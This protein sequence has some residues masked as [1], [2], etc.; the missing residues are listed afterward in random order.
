MEIS[1]SRIIIIGRGASLKHFPLANELANCLTIGLNIS[2]FNNHKFDYSFTSESFE[3]NLLFKDVQPIFVGSIKFKLGVLLSY[4]DKRSL[5]DVEVGL[6]GFDFDGYSRDDDILK[7]N[8]TSSIQRRVDIFSQLEALNRLKKSFSRVKIV[9]FGFDINSD[10]DPRLGWYGVR[11]NI[12]K[13]NVEV[14]AEI[15][16]NHHGDTKKLLSLIEGAKTA[17]AN[18][19]KL[20]KRDVNTF[21]S[22][23]KL[24]EVYHSPFGKTF[25]D[26]RMALE[27]TTEQ[28]YLAHELAKE[29]N[30]NIFYSTLDLPSYQWAIKSGFDRVKLPSTISNKKRFLNEVAKMPTKELV[31]STGMTDNAYEEWILNTFKKVEKIFLLQCTS[32]Y[33]TFYKDVNLGVVSH[34]KELSKIHPSVL[35]GLSSH[36]SGSIASMMAVAAGAKM[37][38]KH[39][40]IGVNDWS[41][42]D[43]TAL[44]VGTAFNDFVSEIRLAEEIMGDSKKKVLESEHH[45]Y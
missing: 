44:D 13:Y 28:S 45:K 32:S 40:K 7:V 5:E 11:K 24:N 12:K 26:Y 21:Y 2:E 37:I 43:D 33:P 27:L 25:R 19:V 31:I 42:F 6:I 9:R 16:T 14:V 39:I 29:L 17:G 34:Y 10:S 22:K 41:H 35:P 1:K 36:D 30:M 20:Q 8:V 38:E 15:T 3:S 4:I 23:N 18:T